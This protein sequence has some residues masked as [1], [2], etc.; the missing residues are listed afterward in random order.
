[1]LTITFLL[2]VKLHRVCIKSL[3][4]VDQDEGEEAYLEVY[5][6]GSEEEYNESKEL[7]SESMQQPTE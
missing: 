6:G 7:T 5:D 1:M 3:D 4:L 2:V